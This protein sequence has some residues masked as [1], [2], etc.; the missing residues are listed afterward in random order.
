MITVCSQWAI[1]VSFDHLNR[2]R[3]WE[4]HNLLISL[5]DTHLR[6]L[7]QWDQKVQREKG[8]WRTYSF[9]FQ[10]MKNKLGLNNSSHLYNSEP[11]ADGRNS[12]NELAAYCLLSFILR[13][14]TRISSP[15]KAVNNKTFFFLCV[16]YRQW[17]AFGWWMND[18]AYTILNVR[19]FVG[20]FSD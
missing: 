13:C 1:E 5:S 7:S 19:S 8:Y 2:Q 10:L 15:E 17:A 16:W 14:Y 3:G 11:L 12:W 20:T 4:S 6:L 9:Q 18:K